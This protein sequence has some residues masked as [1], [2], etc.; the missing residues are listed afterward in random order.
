M[1]EF[2]RLLKPFTFGDKRLNM[3]ATVVFDEEMATRHA[4]SLIIS[5]RVWML[6]LVNFCSDHE[7]IAEHSHPVV[8]VSITAQCNRVKWTNLTLVQLDSQ[9]KFGESG[10]GRYSCLQV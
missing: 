6:A 5:V 1:V 3:A 4:S 7:A 9:Q 2:L 10:P 8:E